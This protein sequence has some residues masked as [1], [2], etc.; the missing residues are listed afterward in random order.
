MPWRFFLLVYVKVSDLKAVKPKNSKREP[1][2]TTN[3][4][5]LDPYLLKNKFLKTS[6]LPIDQGSGRYAAVKNYLPCN[7]ETI[8]KIL[9]CYNFDSV[10]SIKYHSANAFICII[11]K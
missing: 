4:K 9:N 8:E 10:M 7:F 6:T 1:N 2:I 5:Y 11:L 3:N